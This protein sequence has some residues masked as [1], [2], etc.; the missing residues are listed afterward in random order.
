MNP[1]VGGTGFQPVAHRNFAQVQFK[2]KSVGREARKKPKYS[3]NHR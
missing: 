3:H 1:I 2:N